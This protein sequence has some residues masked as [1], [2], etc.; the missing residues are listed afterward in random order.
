MPF[1]VLLVCTGNTCRS[2]MAEGILRSM[3]R[4]GEA[5]TGGEDRVHVFSAGTAG[6]AGFPA[7]E[8]AREVSASR[9]VD[10]SGHLSRALTADTIERAGLILAMTGRHVD[11]VLA[12]SPA[13]SERTFLLSDYAGSGREEVPDPMGGRREDYETAYDMIEGYLRL[14]LPRILESAGEE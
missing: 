6:L 10:I 2:A 12:E 1:S 9:G 4:E 13:A 5:G 14:A 8:L 7:S 3:L 11:R